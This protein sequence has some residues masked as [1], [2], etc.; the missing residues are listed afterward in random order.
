MVSERAL[1]PRVTF[2]SRVELSASRA[3]GQKVEP[4]LDSGRMS[5]NPA[6]AMKT[7]SGRALSVSVWSSEKDTSLVGWPKP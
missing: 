1:L 6:S 7:L 2:L 3:V 5:S 4:T